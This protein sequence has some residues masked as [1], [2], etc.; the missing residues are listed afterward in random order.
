L[1]LGR[2]QIQSL[3]KKLDD[4][5][6]I[7]KILLNG[8]LLLS[9][10][11][12]GDVNIRAVLGDVCGDRFCLTTIRLP[13]GTSSY[14]FS[15][16]GQIFACILGGGEGKVY[17]LEVLNRLSPLA[18][19]TRINVYSFNEDMLGNLL[20]D[21]NAV[22]SGRVSKPIETKPVD[23]KSYIVKGLKE[24][25]I[26]ASD[27]ALAEA[28]DYAVIDL[29]CNT[30]VPAPPKDVFLT[31]LKYYIEAFSVRG[32][33][34]KVRIVLHHKKTHTETFD[35]GDRINVWRALGSVP[36]VLWR[37]R[38]YIDKFK[39]KIKGG[40]LEISLI[41]KRLSLYS[42]ANMDIVAR[43]VWEEIK[44]IWEGDVVVKVKLGALGL[45]SR[46]P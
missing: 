16:G 37:H 5:V 9:D 41:L 24:I 2:E 34:R 13:D 28:K 21:I 43:E 18:S 14:I 22:L 11:I 36:K 15:R 1:A 4:V 38:L 6:L 40:R 46:A 30:D 17:G 10:K 42:T 25:G 20:A 45:E 27:V 29:V 39:Y 12:S 31:T 35:I 23:P 7:S 44:K 33:K 19:G 32:L 3:S 26:L 8:S